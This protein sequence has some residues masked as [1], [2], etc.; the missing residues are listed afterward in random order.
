MKILR[1]DT[2]RCMACRNCERVCA[3][4]ESGGFLREHAHIHVRFDTERRVIDTSTCRQCDPAPCL[5]QC[6][7]GAIQRDP[8]TLALVV[9]EA[10]CIGCRTCLDACR[11]GHI[12]FDERRGVASKCDLC[13]GHPRCLQ[14]CMSG[15]IHLEEAHVPAEEPA[16]VLHH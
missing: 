4:G 13:G 7:V 11:S 6:P 15:A 16:L 9:V 1:I 3:F 5:E 8:K 14:F 12:H 10:E 2:S